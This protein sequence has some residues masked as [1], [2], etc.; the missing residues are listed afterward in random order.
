MDVALEEKLCDLYDVFV[1]GMDEHSGSQ[2]RKLYS[3]VSSS[4]TF[5]FCHSLSI[6]F[7]DPFKNIRLDLA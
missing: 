5:I 2:I 7:P 1:E 6:C 4:P 3:D